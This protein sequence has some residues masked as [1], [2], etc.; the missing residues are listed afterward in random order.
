MNYDEK[1]IDIDL[2]YI[3]VSEVMN[4]DEC[5]YLMNAFDKNIGSVKDQL[6]RE[7]EVPKDERDWSWYNGAKTA[8]KSM[9][10]KRM[11]C[12]ERK[13]VLG[14]EMKAKKHTINLNKK[15]EAEQVF[16]NT[17]KVILPKEM[18]NKIW[19]CVHLSHPHLKPEK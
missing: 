18:F 14:R 10:N 7:L 12:Q 8:L 2:K 17:A 3:D 6:R 9:K 11:L 15:V 5:I 16:V 13:G 4:Y 19:E 1:Y